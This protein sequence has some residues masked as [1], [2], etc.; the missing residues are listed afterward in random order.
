MTKYDLIDLL[1]GYDFSPD[2]SDYCDALC[3]VADALC[4]EG[5]DLTS[6]DLRSRVDELPDD[7]TE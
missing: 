5:D 7:W 4:V 2:S 6:D 3:I 1:A